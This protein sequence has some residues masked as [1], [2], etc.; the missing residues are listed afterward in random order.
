MPMLISCPVLLKHIV[1]REPCMHCNSG[2]PMMLPEGQS[3]SGSTHSNWPRSNL[4]QTHIIS[5]CYCPHVCRKLGL[6]KKHNEHAIWSIPYLYEYIQAGLRLPGTN[7]RY[8]KRIEQPC[9]RIANSLDVCAVHSSCRIGYD[10]HGQL[11]QIGCC[12]QA[13]RSQNNLPIQ[14]FTDQHIY[15][16]NRRRCFSQF[17]DVVTA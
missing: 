15:L 8:I 5:K 13:T 7:S 17:S 6:F 9:Y 2:L 10:F 14:G 12:L 11:L 4:Y 1:S 3:Q 16:V